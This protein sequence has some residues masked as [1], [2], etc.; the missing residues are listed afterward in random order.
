MIRIMNE[1]AMNPNNLAM[2]AERMKT[3]TPEGIGDM[4]K[5]VNI[6]MAAFM[7][8]SCPLMKS[9]HS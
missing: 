1:E 4:I 2:T 9:F 5:E 8:S 6:K 3:M 7:L